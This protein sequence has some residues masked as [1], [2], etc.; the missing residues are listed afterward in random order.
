MT[1]FIPGYTPTMELWQWHYLSLI[2]LATMVLFVSLTIITSNS[3]RESPL[4]IQVFA[5][6]SILTWLT[7]YGLMIVLFLHLAFYGSPAPL[8]AK[9]IVTF[10][11]FGSIWLVTRIVFFYRRTA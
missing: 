5:A 1:T 6:V 2:A 3:I 4:F 9:I 10:L 8:G 7:P 11:T